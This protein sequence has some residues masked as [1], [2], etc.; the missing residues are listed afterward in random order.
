[1]FGS[2]GE[3][4]ADSTRVFT[5]C[6]GPKEKEA[7]IEARLP[8]LP[9]GDGGGVD[10]EGV[11][12]RDIR[13]GQVVSSRKQSQHVTRK[14]VQLIERLLNKDYEQKMNS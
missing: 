13:A 11:C 12:R 7:E 2:R 8:A 9:D 14:R 1:M 6:C 3:W 10:L 5:R 4:L